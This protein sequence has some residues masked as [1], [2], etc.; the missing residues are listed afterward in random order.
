MSINKDIITVKKEKDDYN[1]EVIK[2]Y[3]NDKKFGG[4][5]FIDDAIYFKLFYTHIK[6]LQNQGCKIIFE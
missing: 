4:D 6:Q 5:Y 3:L 2:I 1:K